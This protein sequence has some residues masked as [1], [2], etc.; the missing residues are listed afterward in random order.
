MKKIIKKNTIGIL[1]KNDL[2]IKVF[3]E[4]KGRGVFEE[5]LR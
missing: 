3:K 2:S 4:G 5:K 1:V